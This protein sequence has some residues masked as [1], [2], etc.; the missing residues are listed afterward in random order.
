MKRYIEGTSIRIK[1]AFVCDFRDFNNDLIKINDQERSFVFFIKGE[2]VI[3][4]NL[5]LELDTLTN[6]EEWL[7]EAVKSR[8][9]TKI[10]LPK[11]SR[12]L[13]ESY[14]IDGKLTNEIKDSL[15][16]LHSNGIYQG[17][18][19]DTYSKILCSPYEILVKSIFHLEKQKNR[20][21]NHLYPFLFKKHVTEQS[22]VIDFKA[23]NVLKDK[24]GVYFFTCNDEIVYV[25]KSSNFKNEYNGYRSG[26][27]NNSFPNNNG[28]RGKINMKLAEKVK[29]GKEFQNIKWYNLPIDKSNVNEI[30]EK[31]KAKG[32]DFDQ[33]F[34]KNNPKLDFFETLIMSLISQE[35]WN[36]DNGGFKNFIFIH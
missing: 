29:K 13:L 24:A 15:K 7:Q 20:S 3:N 2:E 32:V 28:T 11:L 22:S 27:F 35:K 21:L 18:I 9:L 26:K 14:L 19:L 8:G 4:T 36:I 30:F 16:E 23:S 1:G 25:G 17:D 31:L 34:K 33:T 6:I 5:S 12:Q 10:Q